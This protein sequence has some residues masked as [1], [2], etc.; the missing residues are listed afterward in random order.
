VD[1]GVM[2]TILGP[3]PSRN[4]RRAI[5]RCDCGAEFTAR[6]TDV[7]RGV[8]KSCGCQNKRFK[9]RR[10]SVDL[11]E[12]RVSFVPASKWMNDAVLC[13]ALVALLNPP[14]GRLPYVQ[15]VSVAWVCERLGCEPHHILRWPLLSAIEAD[16][17][18]ERMW[19]RR[20]AAGD[21]FGTDTAARGERSAA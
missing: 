18:G 15:P 14:W 11:P 5:Y 4:G 10:R 1:G 9:N 7:A 12:L 3:A 17:E 13:D 2:L 8:V 19:G 21:V 20:I 16:P 6:V